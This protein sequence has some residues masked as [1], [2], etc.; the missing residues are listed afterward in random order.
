MVL[1]RTQNLVLWQIAQHKYGWGYVT[2]FGQRSAARALQRAGLITVRHIDYRC[3]LTRAGVLEV[4]RRWPKSPSALRS[5]T[6]PD[7]GW[8]PPGDKDVAA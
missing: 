1:T 7:D 4:A 2:Q 8:S 3:D 6:R 5:Y